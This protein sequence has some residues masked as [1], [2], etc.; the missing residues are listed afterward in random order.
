[1]APP[2]LWAGHVATARSGS[3]GPPSPLMTNRR[4]SAASPAIQQSPPAHHSS[5]NMYDRSFDS[6]HSPSLPRIV[7]LESRDSQ[8][9]SSKN[10]VLMNGHPASLGRYSPPRQ[11]RQPSRPAFALSPH[12]M[13][14]S[15]K[16]SGSSSFSNI[17]TPAT[18][19][20]TP[21]TPIEDRKL[22]RRLPPISTVSLQVKAGSPYADPD[23]QPNYKPF[24]N[25]I[26]SYALPPPLHSPFLSSS[27]QGKQTMLRC[28]GPGSGVGKQMLS[29]PPKTW[30]SLLYAN[31][32]YFQI[33]RNLTLAGI[34]ADLSVDLRNRAREATEPSPSP[35]RLI[36]PDPNP[37]SPERDQR[38]QSI[39]GETS[40][41]SFP[42]PPVDGLSVLAYAGRMVDRG[43]R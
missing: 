7:P 43:G 22:Q 2:T 6:A 21:T 9:M 16:S 14:T 8:F 27:A 20:H 36:L 35:N 30:N 15:S 32:R 23:G 33:I 31:P 5:E 42:S 4:E 13:S 10:Q 28:D 12:S 41:E 37:E 40:S 39:K 19:V 17:G 29:P 18:S 38:A 25:Q 3:S 24:S 34:V 26:S 1:M 11:S